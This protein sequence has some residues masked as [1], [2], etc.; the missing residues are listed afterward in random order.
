[1]NI[2]IG[3]CGLGIQ[4]SGHKV[5]LLYADIE[6][7]CLMEEIFQSKLNCP[8]ERIDVVNKDV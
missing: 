2:L 6:E 5:V 1:M 7:V 4:V 8:V 3:V